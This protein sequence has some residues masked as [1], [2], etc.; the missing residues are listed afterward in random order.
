[1]INNLKLWCQKIMPRPR[2]NPNEEYFTISVRIPTLIKEK[3]Q[4]RALKHRRSLNQ[5]IVWLLQLALDLLEKD[6]F[7]GAK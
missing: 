1:M 2:L 6:P 3:L 7:L 5:E 4:D